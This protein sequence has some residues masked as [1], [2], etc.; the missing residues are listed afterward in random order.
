MVRRLLL[1]LVALLLT[2]AALARFASAQGTAPLAPVRV[3][4]T[5]WLADHLRDPNVVVIEVEMEGMATLAH[6][7]GTRAIGYRGFVANRGALGTELPA[8]DKLRAT[9]EQLGVG[10]STLVVL[11]TAH[12]APMASRALLSLDYLGLRH[13]AWLDGGVPKWVAEGRAMS[14]EA[15]PVTRGRITSPV[16]PDLVV[17][18]A[19]ITAHLGKPGTAF[20][21]TRTDGEYVGAGERHGMP[22]AGHLAGARQL[23]WEQLFV[24][25]ASMQLKARDALARLYAERMKP[26]DTVVTYCWVGYRASMTYIAARTLGLP[27]RFYDGSYQ[28]WLQR[29]L[30]V[31]AGATP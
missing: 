3:V 27:A 11:T 25:P 19:W 24:S 13:L 9:F 12:E 4:T 23:E 26:G 21:D 7:P 22:S 6:I 14:T 31:V 1:A 18:A 30:P 15:T 5:A 16:R 20:I 29:A 10:D 2:S 8:D 17:D 28:D